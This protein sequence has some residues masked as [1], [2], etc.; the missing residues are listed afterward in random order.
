MCDDICLDFL[1][2]SFFSIVKHRPL[3]PS[4]GPLQPSIG[5]KIFTDRVRFFSATKDGLLGTQIPVK[6]LICAIGSKVPLFPY[7]RG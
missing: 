3:Q 7:N 5:T 2:R 4:I 6:T 1:G